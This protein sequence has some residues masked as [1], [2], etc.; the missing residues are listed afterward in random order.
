MT[1]TWNEYWT[2]EQTFFGKT[3]TFVRKNIITRELAS[4]LKKYFPKEGL[5]LDAGSGSSETSLKIKNRKIIALDLSHLV[6]KKVNPSL[7]IDS[8][9]NS[10]IFS[11][12]FKDNS[13]DG[14]FNLGVMEHFVFDDIIKILNEFYRTLKKDSYCI[15][16]WPSVHGPTNLIFSTL[17][18]ILKK[19]YFPDEVSLYRNKKWLKNII[20]DSS[21]KLV[22][23]RWPLKGGLIYH[24]VILRK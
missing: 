15:L 24:E 5:F 1:S 10:S 20:K 17:G 18:F 9:I 3:L 6:L 2:K 21:F 12:P 11:L 4:T 16:F 22:K 8:K 13:L 14:I 23:V 19:Q 7:P